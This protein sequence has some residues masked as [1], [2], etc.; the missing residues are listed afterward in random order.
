MEKFINFRSEARCEKNSFGCRKGK[1]FPLVESFVSHDTK[2]W[3]LFKRI[4]SSLSDR[5]SQDESF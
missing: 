4:K 5:E 3:K 2:R 1:L